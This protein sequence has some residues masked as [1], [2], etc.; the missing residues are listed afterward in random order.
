MMF[1]GLLQSRV[2]AFQA[3]SNK[4]PTVGTKLSFYSH[5]YIHNVPSLLSANNNFTF[6]RNSCRYLGEND[7]LASTGRER[8]YFRKTSNIPG[9]TI[10]VS[11]SKL[12][13]VSGDNENDS[14]NEIDFDPTWTYTPYV[15]PSPRR[16]KSNASRR[17]F[18]SS[19]N[20]ETPKS[21]KIPLDLVDITFSRSSGAGGQNVNKVNSRVSITFH[22]PSATWIP[23]EVRERIKESDKHKNRINKEGLF[24]VSS[25]EHRT[26]A[27]NRATVMK[28]VQDIVLECW[29]RPKI[30]KLRKGISK[31][32]KMKNKEQKRRRSDVK[33]KR[34]KV[35]F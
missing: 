32:Q 34:G 22:L 12:F 16:G 1:A 8:I 35:D 2:L 31:N 29:P 17:R 6:R 20:W 9:R 19:S 25:Q 15:T 4:S 7:D 33:K 26:Q 27:M 30:R 11:A 13:G 28:K 5:R 21:I 23:A 24:S 18:S 10:I 14:Q 3:I